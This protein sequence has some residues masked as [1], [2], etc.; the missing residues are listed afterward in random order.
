M[1]RS[2]DLCDPASA[3]RVERELS[4]RAK[5]PYL[6]LRPEVRDKTTGK[7]RKRSVWWI[8]DAGKQPVVTGCAPE[9]RTGAA[10]ALAEYIS[11]N[12]SPARDKER[13]ARSI[14]V[15]DVLTVYGEDVAPK[16]ARP[17]KTAARL[18]QLG[19]YWDGKSV[20]DVDGKSVRAYGEWRKKQ[21]WKSS[22]PE[23]TG[24][25]PR[26]ITDGGVR[27]ELEDLQ[28]ALNHYLKEGHM[29]ETIRV[30]LPPK[31]VP[32]DR[33]LERDEAAKLL[34]TMWMHKE[35]QTRFRG[36]DTGKVITTKKRPHRHLARFLLVG[37]YTGTRAAAI[38]GAA[39]Q[40]TEGRGWVDLKRG[41]FHRRAMGAA[42][43]KKRQPPV[44]LPKRLLAHIRRWA[45]TPRLDGSMPESVVEH[46]GKLV[47]EVNKGFSVAVRNAGLGPDVTPHTLR[48]TC[49]T[50]M[51][52]AGVDLWQ[53]AAFLGM[54]VQMLER[55]Y[56]H[57]RPD[58]QSEAA[59]ALDRGG[60]RVVES[61]DIEDAFTRRAA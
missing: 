45:R 24:N 17:H 31:S 2:L 48:H 40:P 53:A 38:C 59:N 19:E 44:R 61:L 28:A 23:K 46:Y 10:R 56:G 32:K 34:W 52:Q 7:L 3:C 39:F 37:I 60:R 26:A 29:R 18:L 11:E 58:Y 9:D 22:K 33:Y 1:A 12:Y 54:T 21:S 30:P 14:L 35:K 41:V 5:G 57:H 25:K 6:W 8:R 50:W 15:T 47:G 13:P 43:T 36:I 42:V 16:H 49:A 27:R 55:V 4:R 20:A 51:M